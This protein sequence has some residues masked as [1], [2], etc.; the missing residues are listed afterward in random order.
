MSVE[1]RKNVY[2]ITNTKT[3]V[4][5]NK[6]VTNFEAEILVRGT[7]DF[8]VCILSQTELDNGKIDYKNVDKKRTFY[9]FK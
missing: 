8:K 1:E 3:L 5:I 4:D 7:T 6:D 9:E 2:H